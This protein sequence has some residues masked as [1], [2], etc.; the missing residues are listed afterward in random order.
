[1]NLERRAAVLAIVVFS[2]VGCGRPDR[3][4][5]RVVEICSPCRRGDCR[6]KRR[7]SLTA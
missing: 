3:L 1:M 2:I 4:S 5:R 6:R 7:A